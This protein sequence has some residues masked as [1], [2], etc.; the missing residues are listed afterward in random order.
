MSKPTGTG[1]LLYRRGVTPATFIG[2]SDRINKEK[3]QQKEQAGSGTTPSKAPTEGHTVTTTLPQRVSRGDH[4]PVETTTNLAPH[5][6]TTQRT[7]SGNVRT[8][9]TQPRTSKGET[10]LPTQ[11][12]QTTQQRVS[13]GETNLPPAQR[14]I[15]KGDT[16]PKANIT[17]VHHASPP[18]VAGVDTVVFTTGPSQNPRPLLYVRGGAKRPVT[19][20]LQ[21]NTV[22][23]RTTAN[24][25][26]S[27]VRTRQA[28]YSAKTES[29]DS[30]V[31]AGKK[32]S[33]SNINESATPV[34]PRGERTG[35]DTSRRAN[36]LK[37][38][39][40][41]DSNISDA[42]QRATN[43]AKGVTTS[44]LDKLN[45]QQLK[46][47]LN[48]TRKEINVLVDNFKKLQKDNSDTN[49]IIE[50][51]TRDKTALERNTDKLSQELKQQFEQ[52]AKIKPMERELEELRNKIG[53]SGGVSSAEVT[54]LQR[55]NVKLQETVKKLTL[56]KQ[57]LSDSS[58]VVSDL[59]EARNRLQAEN[60]ENLMTIAL[61][62]EQVTSLKTEVDTAYSQKQGANVDLAIRVEKLQKE[63]DS[64]TKE[65]AGVKAD[66]DSLSSTLQS[67]RDDLKNAFSGNASK[68]MIDKLTQERD[69]L[70]K[71][72]A[73]LTKD[74]DT[75]KADKNTAQTNLEK[76]KTHLNDTIIKLKEELST[77]KEES[78]KSQ[79]SY[80]SLRTEKTKTEKENITLKKDLETAQQERNQAK[81]DLLETQKK[82]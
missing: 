13:R 81:K 71:T 68:T 25:D 30:V 58:N 62:E 72:Q 32:T 60:D 82:S 36:L 39:K 3:E 53:Q 59:K 5:S 55:D 6:T 9:A 77:L 40:P 27:G 46:D 69:Q 11:P 22:I 23:R 2:A 19:A 47:Q 70:V 51:L 12:A 44:E 75:A 50:T 17:P 31:A 35:G 38:N 33:S 29:N 73:Q 42:I 34:S 54:R 41:P 74:L 16:S 64:T 20:Q 14:K 80:D 67:T 76:S 21:D 7:T 66:R 52:N 78:G 26:I 28:L 43:I 63:L 1:Q 79:T 65:L 61:L 24:V 56:E 49:K 8:T 48:D 10:S 4:R 18:P 37:E 57:E 45:P 15:S